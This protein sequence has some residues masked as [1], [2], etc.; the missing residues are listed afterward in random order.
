MV[1]SLC[2]IG[3][4]MGWFNE[5]RIA[6]DLASNRMSTCCA[7]VSTTSP[8]L[9][10]CLGSSIRCVLRLPKSVQQS[11]HPC[12]RSSSCL[13]ARPVTCSSQDVGRPRTGEC[14]PSS[15]GPGL[16]MLLYQHVWLLPGQLYHPTRLLRCLALHYSAS[17]FRIQAWNF[18]VTTLES[19]KSVGVRK[20]PPIFCDRSLSVS[21][22]R[23][24]RH[25]ANKEF[26]H[27][28]RRRHS[29]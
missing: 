18:T 3:L 1:Q 25:R 24:P 7:G 12:C 6:G 20:G 10:G 19:H 17:L 16:Q 27:R 4:A 9:S 2:P 21:G 15:V 11:P 5:G 28:R 23:F 26:I 14:R 22:R 8:G 13:L 29:C